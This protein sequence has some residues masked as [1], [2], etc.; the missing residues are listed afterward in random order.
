MPMPEI[1]H[2]FP[3]VPLAW[4]LRAAGHEVAFLGGGPAN[5]VRNAGI[6]LVDPVP[7]LVPDEE[8]PAL[9]DQLPAIYA[10]MARMSTS[11]LLALK[12]TKVRPW[13]RF[14]DPFVDA[15]LR[16]RPE[17]IVFDPTSCAGLVAAAHLRVPAV[18]LGSMLMRVTPALLR[19]LAAPAFR[20]HRV[21]LPER[22]GMVD[23]APAGLME[24][25]PEPP[26]PAAVSA[27]WAMRYVPFNGG[28]VLPA[29]LAE[30]PARRR[31]A[32]ALGPVSPRSGGNE[33]YRRVLDAAGT[34]DAEIALT[35][36]G[37]AAAGLGAV[38]DNVRATG[39]IP[40][41]ELLRSCSAVLHHGGGGSTLTACVAGL[42]QLVVA[43]GCDNEYHGRRLRE[44]GC[45]L[46]RTA[47]E[48][49][50]AAITAVLSDVDLQR[51]ARRLRAE[52]D[53]LPSPAA[54]VGDLVGFA[55]A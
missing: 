14:T 1:G 16:L 48:L 51:A 44:Y 40:L 11:D 10:S 45:A 25:P 17:L 20:R 49:D 15:A 2:A 31:I 28:G 53:R 47:E 50:A 29:W 21:E 39:W 55:R 52:F 7:S 36:S 37:P 24:P 19:E 13:D 43:Q 35:L 12:S 18:G 41:A 32:V 42:P 30:P 46:T 9:A 8:L 33:R 34:I 54:L 38:P 6:P 23:P 5:E 4:A 3:M 27:T 22:I 26:D